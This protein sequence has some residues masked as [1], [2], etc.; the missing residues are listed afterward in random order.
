MYQRTWLNGVN[1]NPAFGPELLGIVQINQ[2]EALATHVLDT[3]R[4][5]VS[6]S[7]A[8]PVTGMLT[9]E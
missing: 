8:N 1:V 5:L 3:W 9:I 6:K 2:P 4:T 7:K